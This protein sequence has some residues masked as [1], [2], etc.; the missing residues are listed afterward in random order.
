MGDDNEKVDSS[1]IILKLHNIIMTASVKVEAH[2]LM[3]IRAIRYDP[4]TK[5][6]GVSI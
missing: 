6:G 2:T 1:L 5:L 3:V 4:E